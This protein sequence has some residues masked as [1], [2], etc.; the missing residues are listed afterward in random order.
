M[1]TLDDNSAL[2]NLRGLESLGELSDLSLFNVGPTV[3]LMPIRDLR[4]L[5][6]ITVSS[7]YTPSLSWLPASVTALF[8]EDIR[9]WEGGGE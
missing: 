7:Q 5:Q 6:K 1:L 8:L 3:D 2:T 4:T 9:R